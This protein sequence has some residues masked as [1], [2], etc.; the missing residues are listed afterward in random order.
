MAFT[1]Q[2]TV[3]RQGRVKRFPEE[4]GNLTWIKAIKDGVD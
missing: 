4:S 3:S 1:G 2:D